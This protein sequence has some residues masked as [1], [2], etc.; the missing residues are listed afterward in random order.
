MLKNFFN[1][2]DINENYINKI[3]NPLS[4]SKT[5]KGKNIGLLF[6]KQS[7]RTRLSFSVGISRLGGNAIDLKI[8]EL[9]FRT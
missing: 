2:S 1:I 9:N 5:L 8:E 4:Y 3:I 6:E 7:T